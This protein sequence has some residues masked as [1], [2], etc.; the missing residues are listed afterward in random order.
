[1]KINYLGPFAEERQLSIIGYVNDLIQFQ[2]DYSPKFEINQYNPKINKL[3]N[4]LPTLWKMRFARYVDY[5]SQVRKLPNY[6][7]T[8]VAD[9]AYAHLARHI[10]SKVKIITV[11]DLIPLVYEKKLQ[12]TLYNQGGTGR[13]KR[14][15]HLFW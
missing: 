15:A 7:I 10:K 9:Q 3:Y 1:M 6:D 2:K 12:K 13:E 8:H 5:P 11:N 14:K 4:L